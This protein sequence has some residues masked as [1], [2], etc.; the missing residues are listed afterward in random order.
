MLALLLPGCESCIARVF[1]EPPPQRG[2]AAY[3]LGL[4]PAELTRQLSWPARPRVDQEVALTANNAVEPWTVAR[5]RLRIREALQQVVIDADD[6]E[7]VSEQG[8]TVGAI[9]VAPG[10]RRI[11][12]E[13]GKFGQI[14]LQPPTRLR[15]P[16][17][18]WRAEDMIEDVLIDRVQVDALESGLSGVLL[19]G[20]R[21]VVMNSRV[22]ARYHAVYLG[23]TAPVQSQDVVI[24]GCS[25]YSTGESPTVVLSDV[26]RA[27]VVDSWLEN[28]VLSALRVHGESEWVVA[29]SNVLVGG[30]VMIGT[31][32]RDEIDQAW[33]W[34]N[35]I[36]HATPLL[37]SLEP[38]RVRSLTLAA[39]LIYSD[40]ATCMWCGRT[41][42]SWLVNGNRIRAYRAPPPRP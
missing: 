10:R 25:L 13:G 29:R 7:V 1:P 6:V 16:P 11:R 34:V 24:A 19:R 33:V 32:P 5:R 3:G 20:H 15:E 9:I 8:A 39:N 37:L 40:G 22:D 36:H 12:I 2:E 26:V 38:D 21:I 14:V 23:D 30:G 35:T 27:V 28:P 31:D 17:P 18:A 41:P 42:E 4:I